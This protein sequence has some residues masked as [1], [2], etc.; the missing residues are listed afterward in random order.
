MQATS[1]KCS[2][3][4]ST[5]TS[6]SMDVSNIRDASKNRDA[7]TADS[8]KKQGSQ[9]QQCPVFMEAND[10]RDAMVASKNMDVW[11]NRVASNIMKSS[12]SRETVTT[13]MPVAETSE[14][15]EFRGNP[16]QILKAKIH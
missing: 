6:K 13:E 5:D 7:F 4:I 2:S 12:N 11:K 1:A 14:T 15:Q 10:S 9:Q 8:L 16:Q 3:S